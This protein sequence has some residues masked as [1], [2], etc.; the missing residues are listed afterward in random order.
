MKKN[1]FV[2]QSW[3]ILYTIVEIFCSGVEIFVQSG[4]ICS[5]CKYFVMCGN[6]MWCVEI[7]CAVCKYFAQVWKYSI[8]KSANL[9]SN[10]IFQIAQHRN[11]CWYANRPRFHSLVITIN[12]INSAWKFTPTRF[13]MKQRPTMNK[14]RENNYWVA[15]HVHKKSSFSPFRF[16]LL[17]PKVLLD[18]LRP[19]I[20]THPIQLVKPTY[21]CEGDLSVE[22]LI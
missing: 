16:Y 3:N 22:D 9:C 1:F 13:W 6:I 8:W 10:W 17:A 14:P 7:F 18:Y 11:G 15:I 5:E 21:S 12:H 20:T 19:L 2:V 4:N